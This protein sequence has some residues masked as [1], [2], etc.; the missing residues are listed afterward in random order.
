MRA[1]GWK[2]LPHGMQQREYIQTNTSIAL[3]SS[4][5]KSEKAAPADAPQQKSTPFNCHGQRPPTGY[6]IGN[7]IR[8]HVLCCL[9]DR[10]SVVYSQAAF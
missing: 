10:N 3:F 8:H 1:K 7:I 6:S 2:G 5:P 4:Y 9:D